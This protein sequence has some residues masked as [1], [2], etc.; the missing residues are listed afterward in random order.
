M[1][2]TRREVVKMGVSLPSWKILVEVAHGLVLVP[3]AR[4]VVVI[5]RESSSCMERVRKCMRSLLFLLSSVAVAV[6]QR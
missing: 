5:F 2:D 1:R 3:V 4:M 6:L